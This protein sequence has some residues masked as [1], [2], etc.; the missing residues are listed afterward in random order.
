MTE[1]ELE[2]HH[3]Y[4]EVEPFFLTHQE[5]ESWQM[6][7]K[8]EQLLREQ[9]RDILKHEREIREIKQ[10]YDDILDPYYHGDHDVDHVIKEHR[11]HHDTH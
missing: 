10:A 1:E 8:E 9:K 11:E 3:E 6:H 4:F 7:K 2:L 5:K